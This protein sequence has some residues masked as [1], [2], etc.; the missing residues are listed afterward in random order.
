MASTSPDSELHLKRQS[1][2]P[3]LQDRRHISER[4]TDSVLAREDC[5]PVQQIEEVDLPAER[6]RSVPEVLLQVQ[7]DL[8]VARVVQ[9]ARLVEDER[10]GVRPSSGKRLFGG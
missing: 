2:Q 3:A 6:L 10:L 9:R 5:V 1:D 8:V 4:V 7:V